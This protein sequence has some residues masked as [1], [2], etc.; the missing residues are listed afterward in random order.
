MHI[1]LVS[2]MY[3]AAAGEDEWPD[4]I[5]CVSDH[6]NADVLFLGAGDPRNPE[7]LE[8]WGTGWN[9]KLFQKFGFEVSDIWDPSVNPAIS[10][11][12][13]VPIER[14][15]DHR[16]IISAHALRSS[17]FIQ[18]NYYETGYDKHLVFT[19]MRDGHLLSGGL[20]GK[21]KS[22]AFDRQER[23]RLDVLL[24]H[25]GRAMRLR[26]QIARHK[27]IERGLSALLD[28]MEKAVFLIDRN[29][30]VLFL[31]GSA[32]DLAR[33]DG[34]IS[35]RR[36]RLSLGQAAQDLRK[37]LAEIEAEIGRAHV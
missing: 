25:L 36:G 23:E 26:H 9:W 28:R 32:E 10:A 19:P 11:G 20:A 8:H 34:G 5:N 31:N 14:A 33:R 29:M 30:K 4:V 21:K 17:E 7:D 2:R 6:I 15:F 13:I 35:V 24:P 27:T 12:M 1:E 18:K 22:R 3:D 16:K 37:A